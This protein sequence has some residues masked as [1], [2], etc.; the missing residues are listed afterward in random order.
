MASR[1]AS[2][3]KSIDSF[4][5]EQ[6]N[7]NTLSKTRRDIGLLNEF[8]QN[9]G[10]ERI[11][12]QIPP[13]ELNNYISE[14]I[15]VV[16]RKDGEEFEPSSLRG[17]ICSFNRYLKTKGYP[18]NIIE[19]KEF[20]QVR[21]ALKAKSKELKKTGKGNKPNAAEAITDDEISVLYEKELLGI[22]NAE[23][24]I[25]TIWYMNTI[26]FGLRAC[27]E[28]RQM[29][30]GDVQLKT[31]T[32]GTEYLE[33]SERQTK[34][35]T[36]EDPR[37]I[38]PVKPKAFAT[39]THK[40]DK[41]P[42]FVYKLYAEK[43]PLSMQDPDAPF[44]LGINHV[45]DSS[46]TIK[47]WFKTAPMGVNKLSSLMRTMS[48][49]AGLD[50]DRRLTN[51]SAR[52]TMVQKLNDNNIPPTH[53]MQLSGHRNVQSINNYSNITKEQQKNMS[54]I[55]SAQSTNMSTSASL[56]QRPVKTTLSAETREVSLSTKS[57]FIPTGPFCGDTINVAVSSSPEAGCLPCLP[58]PLNLKR[59]GR[60]EWLAAKFRRKK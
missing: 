35:R 36:G 24:L 33:Y 37:N 7:R 55:L 50:A 18:A 58:A 46:K 39:Q 20:E 54:T 29:K 23:A 38:R 21:A 27:D 56:V 1:F 10:E 22:S 13:S 2:L 42:V 26:H 60:F 59:K 4:I 47:P 14:F 8:L 32:D 28:H 48:E 6:T 19:D 44:Y 51:H 40:P 12:E 15:V 25:N 3:D 16:R 52:K 41:N 57:S 45:K 34:T 11:L 30:W 5:Q 53:I 43:R 49:K 9:K 31:D 17:L